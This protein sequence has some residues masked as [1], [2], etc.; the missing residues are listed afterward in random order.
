MKMKNHY[1]NEILFKLKELE[2]EYELMVY[3]NNLPSDISANA[4]EWVKKRISG[5][6][7]TDDGE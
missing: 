7:K 6:N 1:E 3:F 2:E 4:A 5:K